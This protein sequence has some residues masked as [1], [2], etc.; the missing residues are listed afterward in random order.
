MTPQEYAKKHLS[1]PYW[2]ENE[3]YRYWKTLPFNS[4][5][6][7]AVLESLKQKIINQIKETK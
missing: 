2:T 5:I 7:L 1:Y 3:L 4:F 6:E